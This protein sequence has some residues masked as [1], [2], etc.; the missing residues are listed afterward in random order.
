M[1][2]SRSIL[3]K[4]VTKL[5][6]GNIESANMKLFKRAHYGVRNVSFEE[7]FAYVLNKWSL[8]ETTKFDVSRQAL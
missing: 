6:K 7:N 5:P 8:R 3:Y 1:L 4:K 2:T